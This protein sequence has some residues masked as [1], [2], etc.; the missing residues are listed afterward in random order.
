MSL[1]LNLL[2]PDKDHLIVNLNGEDSGVLPFTNPLM[3][4]DQRDIQW[5]LEVY[6]AHSLGDP[7]DSE[8]TRIDPNYLSGAKRSSR[9]YFKSAPLFACSISF[10][11]VKP[12]PASLRSALTIL[13]F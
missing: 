4:K 6:G 8:A 11:T 9:P 12:R 5:Y 13:Q 7:D 1:E 2:F 3:D 10:K